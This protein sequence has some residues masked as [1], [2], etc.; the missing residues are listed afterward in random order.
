[1]SG[2]VNKSRGA[3]ANLEAATTTLNE[4]I[5]KECHNLYTDVE[6]GLVDIA[7]S[8]GLSLLPPRKKITIMLIGN[9]SA[10]KSSFINWYIEEHVQRT[11]VAIETQG[12]SFVTSG[13]RRESL[14]GNATLHLY[15]HFKPLQAMPGVVDYLST[16][17]STSKQKKFPLVT[18]VDSPGLVDGD[19]CYPFDVNESILWLAELCDMVFVFFD[20]IGQA[21]CKRTLNIV[22]SISSKHPERMR[23]Y[24]SKADEA[25]HESDRQRVMMQIVQELCKRPGLNKTGFDMPTIYVP[26]P[27]KQVRCVNQ[28]EEVCKDIEKT[29]TQTIQN[30]LN[31]LEKDCDTIGDMVDQ[32]IAKDNQSRAANIKAYLKGGFLYMLTLTLPM[33]LVLSLVLAML[34]EN[35]LVDKLGKEGMEMLKFYISP[36]KSFWAGI[37]AEYQLWA[38]VVLAV[39]TLG[40]MLLARWTS[41]TSSTLSRRQKRQL[42]DKQE[43]VRNVVKNK[44]KSLYNEY[45]QQTVSDQDM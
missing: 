43:Y 38:G 8:L 19:M 28:I 16:E 36:V 9:H 44:K 14:T 33:A 10:G 5:L 25:G 39:I 34:Q 15:P 1:M 20:P 3:T 31:S 26:N 27:N 32:A 11:G 18:F 12:F 17:I 7:D 37:P 4:R 21:L 45:L 29:I 6:H 42:L 30:T 24:L 40:L 41:K 22:E 23:F 35:L 2:R 13:R